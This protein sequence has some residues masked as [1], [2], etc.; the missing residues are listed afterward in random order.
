MEVMRGRSA[1]GKLEKRGDTF[2]GMVWGDPL[3]RSPDGVGMSTVY[4]APGART[5][6]HRHEGGQV[7]HVI[8]GEGMVVTRDGSAARVRAGD[9]VWAP[10]GEE[11]WHGAR[12]DTFFVHTSASVG[13]TAWLGEVTP[14]DYRRGQQVE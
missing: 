3:L 4:F 1:E 7:L 5:Y 11:H 9:V 13:G 6:W 2:T 12:S 8:S 10:S 14:E